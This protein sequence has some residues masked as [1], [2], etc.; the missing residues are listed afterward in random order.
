[1]SDLFQLIEID[2][3][4]EI[5]EEKLSIG[6]ETER[7]DITETRGR[8]LAQNII[9]PIDLPPFSR[10][11]MDGYAVKA[12]DTFGASEGMPIYLDVVGEV[13]MGE[14]AEQIIENGQAVKIATGGMLPKGA[15]AIVM[16][17]YTEALG[18]DIIEVFKSVAKGENIVLQGEDISQDNILLK[19]GDLL[20]S[21]DIGALAGIGIMEVEV[22]S[23]SKVTVFSTGD[24]LVTPRKNPGPGRIRDINSYSIGSM[25]EE[26]GGEV[27]Y[28]GI[29]TD[30]KEELM[31]KVG[32][33]LEKSDLVI[34]SG[35]S[36][37]GTKDL[38]I[39]VLNE[40]GEPGVLVHGIS[41]KP[42][43][44]TILALVNGTTIIGLP[45]HPTSA[46]VVF[47][48]VVAPIIEGLFSNKSNQFQ[49]LIS[50][51][52]SRNIAS[53]KGRE[54]YLRVKLI[55]EGGELWAQPILGKSSLVTTMVEADGLVKIELGKE[56]LEKGREIKVILFN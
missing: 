56:G 10:S 26:V 53:D 20:R 24:E 37:V 9:S 2:K 16:I 1:M 30:N 38:T 32:A 45:G 7:M 27:I 33:S 51:K 48:T 5:F 12:E 28:G 18:E 13:L 11:T 6:L 23:K 22:F 40:L 3:I 52:L 36:S 19:R 4:S 34:L 15:D 42:G 50:A 21:Q 8:V 55:D 41:I 54:E 44:P 14:E 46:M 35:G 39:E 43:K 17:E 31:T 49:S 29:I 25:V 47:K